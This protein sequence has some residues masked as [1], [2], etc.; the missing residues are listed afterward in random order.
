MDKRIYLTLQT[1]GLQDT[2]HAKGACSEV[3][4]IFEAGLLQS[5]YLAKMV[6]RLLLRNVQT[7]MLRNILDDT[8]S[9][10]T[11]CKRLTLLKFF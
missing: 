9:K 6:Q 11:V 4:Q 10:G 7:Q 1:R 5:K 3:G 2:K 8:I